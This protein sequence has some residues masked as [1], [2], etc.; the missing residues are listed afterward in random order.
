MFKTINED[1]FSF[2]ESKKSQFVSLSEDSV[3]ANGVHFLTGIRS[4]G[5]IDTLSD[6]DTEPI[7]FNLNE[8]EEIRYKFDFTA[9]PLLGQALSADLITGVYSSSADQVYE[10]QDSNLVTQQSLFDYIQGY[11]YREDKNYDPSATALRSSSTSVD[12]SVLRLLNFKKDL[13]DD[14]IKKTSFVM[15][16]NRGIPTLTGYVHGPSAITEYSDTNVTGY[17]SALD[18]KNPYNVLGYR[19]RKSFFGVPMNMTPYIADESIDNIINGITI[20]AVIRPYKNISTIFFRRLSNPTD[21]LTQNKFIK[22]ELTKSADGIKDAFRFY[23]RNTAVYPNDSDVFADRVESSFSDEFADDNIQA[24]GLFIPSDVGINIYDGQ[25]HHI[26]VSWSTDELGEGVGDNIERGSG[27]VLGYID[28]YKLFN[29]E[30]VNP[31]LSGSDAANGPVLQSNMFEQRVPVRQ[32]RLRSTDPADAPKNNNIYIG[33]SNFNRSNG[34]ST[35]DVG[36]LL[37]EN[38]EYLEGLY[39]GQIQEIR[40]W[41]QRLKDGTTSVKDGVNT[42]IKVEDS[43]TSVLNTSFN[44][45]YSSS[46]TSTSASNI[47]AWWRFNNLSSTTATDLAGGLSGDEASMTNDPYGNLSALTGYSVG[48]SFM[49]LY[50][51]GDLLLGSSANTFTDESSTSILRTFLYYDL[52]DIVSPIDN[53]LSQGR[54]VRKTIENQIKR[55]GS[56]FYESGQIVL[57][58]ADLNTT[59]DFTWPTSGNIFGFAVSAEDQTAFNIERVKFINEETS[60]RILINAVAEGEEFNYSQNETSYNP[61][62][63][64]SIFENPTTFINTVG[65]YNDNDELLAVAKL[66][67]NIKKD[68]NIQLV[69]QTKLDF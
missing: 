65:F 27:V 47:V 51:T 3:C 59:V 17:T 18:L 52:P 62:T 53:T 43:A 46:L 64:E 30:Q 66:S 6:N 55:A 45:F 15:E 23:I 16:F 58:N 50:D 31:R 1:N 37:D 33:A 34:D 60:H 48:N 2:L 35:G 26:V 40:V 29:R 14:G 61:D 42:L 25:F 49:K 39:D 56:I 63:E 7:I 10:N 9:I 19:S 21:N 12:V 28:G 57:D 11:L 67:N 44:N 20:E 24:S 68:N 8:R 13:L 5:K 36:P 4:I 41:N 54:V 69:L 22:M 38:D 32:V